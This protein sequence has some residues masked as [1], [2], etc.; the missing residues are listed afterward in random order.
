MYFVKTEAKPQFHKILKN[1]PKL[2][3]LGAAQSANDSFDLNRKAVLFLSTGTARAGVDQQ[4]ENNANTASQPL[5][6]NYAFIGDGSLSKK[7]LYNN[8][9]QTI[10]PVEPSALKKN[11]KAIIQTGR[12]V[13]SSNRVVTRP[14]TNASSIAVKP[15]L[16]LT[17]VSPSSFEGTTG[18]RSNF[19][20]RNE[21][22]RGMYG[23]W[24]LQ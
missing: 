12:K 10:K 20:Q 4:Q 8:H 2:E 5:S 6:A 22:S 16:F 14:A 24:N 21:K 15:Q 3:E 19:R 11:S 18:T 17:I 23:T 1:A 9:I 7:S 13:T